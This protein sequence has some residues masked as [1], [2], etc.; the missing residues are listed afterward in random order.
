MMPVLREHSRNEARLA[1]MLHLLSRRTRTAWVVAFMVLAMSGCSA[2]EPGP[3][4]S[5]QLQTL[6]TAEPAELRLLLIDRFGPLWY[7]DRDSYPVG[8][9][10]Q[11]AAIES[12]PE[13]VTDAAAF[14]AVSAKL[15]IDPGA[16]HTDAEKLALYRLWKVVSAV[17]LE[18]VGAGRYRFDYL[19]QPAPGAA[20]GLRTAGIVGADRSITVEQQAAAGQ[21]VCPICLAIGTRI[22]GPDGPISVERVRLGN[23]V[24]TLDAKGRRVAGTVIAIGSTAAPAGHHVIRVT[25]ADG[26]TV[27]ASPGHPLGDGRALAGLRVGDGVDGSRVV[28]LESLA[29]RGAETYDLV[30]SGAT[31]IYL[32]GDIPLGSTLR[33]AGSATSGE[34]VAA[35]PW[36]APVEE[37]LSPRT[38]ASLVTP[39]TVFAR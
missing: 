30:V 7:C 1:R 5:S 29:Y 9:D 18:S 33:Q 20:E 6:P 15:G 34:A 22:E 36:L 10:E 27:T 28:G 12:Y 11:A 23:T 32:A 38:P 37:P 4:P 19:A 26:R 24:W 39:G 16:T 3:S 25:L 21:P 13:M 17:Q 31:G 35:R 14:K 2:G 8:R